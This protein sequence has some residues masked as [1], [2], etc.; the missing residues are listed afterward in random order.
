MTRRVLNTLRQFTASVKFLLSIG[1]LAVLGSVLSAATAVA[2]ANDQAPNKILSEASHPATENW[3]RKQI[4]GWEEH[5]PVF[6]G[7]TEGL[8]AGTRKQRTGIQEKFDALGAMQSLTFQGQ[9][10][11]MDVYLVIFDHGALSWMVGPVA[12]GKVGSSLFGGPTIR[13]GPSPGTEAAVRK[14]IAGFAAGFPAY[15]VMSQSLVS[16][17]FP[18]MSSLGGAAKE[19][20]ALKSLT[21]SKINPQWFDVY[22]AVYEN[23][24]AVWSIAPLVGGRVSSFRISEEALNHST[25][26][27]D[28]EASLRRYVESLEQG[29]PNYNEM[30]PEGVAIVRRNLPNILA[31]IKP[32]GHLQSITFDH[33]APNDTDVYLVSFERGK[34]EWSM[35]PLTPD[36]KVTRRNFRVL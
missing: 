16:Q 11:G 25:P 10:N 26:H 28:R 15:D 30:P 19:F 36:G 7:M 21:F 31:A 24:R 27:P 8:A 23:G 1:L 32:L 33:S 20:G 34:V 35:G 29:A 17:I 9:E 22:D 2:Q 13:L 18:Q 5:Q 14:L 3:L 12:S 4:A 6:E